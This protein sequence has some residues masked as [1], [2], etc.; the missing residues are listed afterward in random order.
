MHPQVVIWLYIHTNI[1][2]YICL[3]ATDVLPSY[4]LRVQSINNP[5]EVLK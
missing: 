4:L 1:H 5:V 3:I 2:M